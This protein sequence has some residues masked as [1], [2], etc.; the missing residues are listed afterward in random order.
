MEKMHTTERMTVGINLQHW[1]QI[2]MW[3]K[4]LSVKKKKKKIQNICRQRIFEFHRLACKMLKLV[5]CLFGNC[6]F[7]LLRG[8][9]KGPFESTIWQRFHSYIRGRIKWNKTMSES[10]WTLLSLAFSESL[11]FPLSPA[12]V[13]HPVMA[14]IAAVDLW[15]GAATL[16]IQHDDDKAVFK[17]CW[18]DQFPPAQAN[19]H[20]ST[21]RARTG[22]HK[23]RVS[24]G[25]ERAII[26][27]RY[28]NVSEVPSLKSC[29]HSQCL[30]SEVLHHSHTSA[31]HLTH[32]HSIHSNGISKSGVK[33][34]KI[35]RAV[36]L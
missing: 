21:W 23:L 31:L 6:L 9:K 25:T 5:F 17:F 13:Y 28:A 10:W 29:C 24:G 4:D 20:Q 16:N 30:H 1:W 7:L 15:T 35:T 14:V 22:A 32:P 19:G 2:C 18:N 8:L 12:T 36:E 26:K 27:W 34:R 3:K 33:K 11:V